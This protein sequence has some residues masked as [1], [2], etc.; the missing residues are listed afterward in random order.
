VG[1]HPKVKKRLKVKKYD[2]ILLA[3]YK[4]YGVEFEDGEEAIAFATKMMEWEEKEKE[5]Y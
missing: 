5:Q 1:R 4:H 3:V 2:L